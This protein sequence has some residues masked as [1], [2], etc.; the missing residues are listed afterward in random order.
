MMK[1]NVH[2]T[3]LLELDQAE[4]VLVQGGVMEQP[5]RKVTAAVVPTT[6][7]FRLMSHFP[8]RRFLGDLFMGRNRIS[9]VKR[10]PQIVCLG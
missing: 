5:M 10:I 6:G 3:G 8:F 9:G 4:L 7:R 1:G 2:M